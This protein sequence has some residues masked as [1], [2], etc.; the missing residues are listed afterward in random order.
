MRPRSAAA[1]PKG[2]KPNSS[3]ADPAAPPASVRGSRILDPLAL[4]A[5][6][7]SPFVSPYQSS[8]TGIGNSCEGV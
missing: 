7:G 6:D 4:M 3:P 5:D 2:R 8:S 1:V